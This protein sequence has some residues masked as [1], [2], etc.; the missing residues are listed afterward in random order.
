MTFDD[1]VN[2]TGEGSVRTSGF[3]RNIPNIFSKRK[4]ESNELG[5]IRVKRLV[6]GT[7]Q[8]RG[9]RIDHSDVRIDDGISVVGT[10]SMTRKIQTS[11]LTTLKNGYNH[12]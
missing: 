12:T 10:I 9:R 1:I 11:R 7:N 2:I 5:V 4:S 3:V 8:G 6:S